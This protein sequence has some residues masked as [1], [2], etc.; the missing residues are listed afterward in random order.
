ME[1]NVTKGRNS[2]TGQPRN[3]LELNTVVSKYMDM[4]QNQN[5]CCVTI[6]NK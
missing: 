1:E 2:P 3:G 4:I 5:Q 6:G